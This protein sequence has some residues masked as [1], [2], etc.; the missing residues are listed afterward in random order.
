MSSMTTEEL[1][2]AGGDPTREQ[3]LAAACQDYLNARLAV[4]AHQR[5]I[6]AFLAAEEVFHA[7]AEEAWQVYEDHVQQ[8]AFFREGASE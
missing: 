2:K 1:T 8:S 6:S 4:A 5:L 7:A 3:F